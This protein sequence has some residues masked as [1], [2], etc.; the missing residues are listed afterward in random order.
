MEIFFIVLLSVILIIGVFI[1]I[2]LIIKNRKL[3]E[4][5]NEY[6]DWFSIFNTRIRETIEM[7][8]EVD[9]RGV[10]EADDEV[11]ASF[12]SI[13]D[14]INDLNELIGTNDENT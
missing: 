4:A 7:I 14:I 13:R 12:K 9:H 6:D 1:I 11:G 10:F 8:N 5:N 3:I 2:N